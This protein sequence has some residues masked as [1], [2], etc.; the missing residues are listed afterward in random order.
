MAL[1][2]K[3]WWQIAAKRELES[4]T[5]AG[6]IAV[7]VAIIGAGFTGLWA[8]YYL[9]KADPGLDVCVIERDFAGVGA[10]G[11][12]GGWAQ[13]D[14]AGSP[15]D[16]EAGQPG[17]A[18]RMARA[19]QATVDEI[20]HETAQLGIDCH[21]SKGGT[22]NPA[23]NQGQLN[24]H[25]NFAKEAHALGMDESDYRILTPE[26]TF[27]RVRIPGIIGGLYSPHCAVIQPYA[28]CAGLADKLI[29][30]GVELYENTPVTAFD[31]K[32]KQLRTD[33]GR[34]RYNTVI[35][36]TEAYTQLLSGHERRLMPFHNYMIVTEPIPAEHWEEIGLRHREAFE[37]G[38]HMIYYGQR[39]RDDR[40][41]IG[42]LSVPYFYGSR[43]NTASWGN[44][45]SHE[46][47]EQ[48]LKQIFPVLAKTRIEHRWGGVLA[49]P[50]DMYPS[51]GLDRTT[52]FAWCGGYVG[53]GV[54][55]ANLGA[56]TLADLILERPSELVDLPWVDHQSPRWEPEPIRWLGATMASSMLNLADW[57]DER[58]NKTL[59]RLSARAADLFG[60]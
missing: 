13:G 7:D 30:M 35:L 53:Q 31:S 11:R 15:K 47:L 51:V 46:M 17:S 45:R 55:A 52:G 57:A 49:A 1:T 54:A 22:V 29:Q 28:L 19:M 12:N 24:R 18:L 21:F 48:T 33:K 16:H 14:M 9:K 40:I 37:D 26:D 42:G 20:E 41:A 43:I 34:V 32:T 44:H 39:T 36:A 23:I 10:S 5:Q 6:D 58:D 59:A 2:D 56:R 4:A 38:R 3:S 60:L 27:E 50:R 8:A 25:R